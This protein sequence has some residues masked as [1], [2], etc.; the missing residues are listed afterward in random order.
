MTSIRLPSGLIV[1]TGLVAQPAR[2]TGFPLLA[3]RVP[4]LTDDQI[5]DVIH[6]SQRVAM[7][8]RFPQATWSRNQGQRGSCNGYAGA[9][10]LSRARVLRGL[11]PVHLSGEYLYAAINGGR[12]QGSTLE[13]AF[14]WLQEHG[15]CRE[16]LVPHEEYRFAWISE[17]AKRDAANFKGLELYAVDTARELHSAI[18]L[19][20]Q[21]VIAVH[22]DDDFTRV[23]AQGRVPP[24]HG[25]GNH[26]VMATDL[27]EIDG[28]FEIEFDFDW[29]RGVGHD[30]L[31]C[32]AWESHLRQTVQNH[33]FY[34]IRS[35]SDGPG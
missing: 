35:T 26:A 32:V 10:A 23:D 31:G 7:R 18:A 14:R 17:E 6:D 13:D 33:Y 24:S 28:R 15:V 21:C 5:R 30:G 16:E 34:A 20:F 4:L 22:V 9:R 1:G 8:E 19:G 12:D 25:V 2:T 11:E 3:D 27:Y 29:G